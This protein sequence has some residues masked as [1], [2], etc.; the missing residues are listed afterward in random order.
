M[1]QSD[2]RSA[3]YFQM[4]RMRGQPLG[5]VYQRYLRE[6]Q[7]GISPDR[8]R[9]LL[10][11]LLDHCKHNV[12]YYHQIMNRLGES[13]RSDPEAYLLTLP[14]LTKDILRDC[15]EPLKSSDLPLRKWAYNTSGG[16]TG[17]PVEFVQ[18]D[19]YNVKSGAVKMIFSRL[20]GKR[21]GEC[22]VSLWG[23]SR[24]ILR[25]R[26]NWKARTVNQLLDMHMVNAYQMTQENMRGFIHLINVCK[27]KLIVS[28]AEAL[29]ELACFA[30]KENLTVLPQSAIMT[31][32]GTL[33]PFIREK[34]EQV[35]QCRVYNRYG[36]REVGDVACERP[37]I[38]GLWVAPWGNYIE[39]VDS[40]GNRLPPGVEGEIL[41][42]SL[43]NY[44]MPLVRYRIGDFGTLADPKENPNAGQVLKFV[45][46]KTNAI[47]R[48]R[49][50]KLVDPGFFEEMMYHKDAVRRFQVVQK[51]YNTILFRIDCLETGL[52]QAEID[53]MI[54]QA[55]LV[56]G[57]DCQVQLEFVPE[58]S[59]TPSGKFQYTIC[60]VTEG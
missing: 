3:L 12:P 32:A 31:S 19:E 7:Q 27:P 38:K 24:D 39:V 33:Y 2:I 28:Y 29:Y 54:H 55:R 26:G 6:V 37:G 50:G 11:Q 10:I 22:E 23:S 60:E 42:T 52:D 58:I 43:T 20:A 9:N 18:D 34:I 21:P 59:P 15:L 41:V 13:Y 30:E 17:E 1:N 49:N 40:H 35:F 53:E 56:M 14:I 46:G 45:H 47:F 16:S 51:D 36:S 44:A 57:P 5:T 8:T 48:T 4:L 25:G